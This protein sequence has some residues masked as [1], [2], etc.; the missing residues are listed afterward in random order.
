[1]KK[2]T[3]ILAVLALTISAFAKLETYDRKSISIFKTAVSSEAKKEATVAN[4]E[5]IHNQLFNR[6]V[7]MGR[8]D[9]NPIPAGVTDA[10]TL[11]AI[12]KEYTKMN[13]EQRAAKQWDIKDDFYGTNFITG[14]NVDKI[15]NGAYILFP[16]LNK[17]KVEPKK[18]KEGKIE[19]YS[20][21]MQIKVDIYAAD[22]KG[23][24]ENPVW[25]PRK[26]GTISAGS[27]DGLGNIFG[28]I[29]G[30]GAKTKDKAVQSATGATL[31]FLEKELRKQEMFKI[32]ALVTKAEPKKD[33]IA[34]GF[35]KNTGINVDDAYSIGYYVKGSDGNQK[36]VETGYVKVRKVNKEE[37]ETQLLIVNNP[38]NENEDDLFN[39]YDQ[40]VEY[41]LVGM[42]IIVSGG[43]SQFH[44]F[45]G[46][47][48]DGKLETVDFSGAASLTVEYDLGKT[49]QIPELYSFLSGEMV[50]GTAEFEIEGEKTDLEPKVIIAEAGLLYKHMMRRHSIYFGGAFNYAFIDLTIENSSKSDD[51]EDTKNLTALGGKAFLGYNYLIDKTIFFDVQVGYRFF[52][53]L[54]DTGDSFWETDEGMGMLDADEKFLGE[55]T[56]E[57]LKPSGLTAKVGI[58]FTL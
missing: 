18:D 37:S 38:K 33:K 12:V 50:F 56:D 55:D 54:K 8:F 9:Y 25:E 14:E 29:T 34:F 7:G 42:N 52:G 31:E 6:F 36:F 32:K 16:K 30:V 23:T 40:A 35:G 28:A 26:V 4:V 46:V 24:E 41:P 3:V 13:L 49:T 11:F 51:D 1:M 44:G 43:M 27:G 10:S 48:D 21:N 17:F 20:C 19:S 53:D 57:L 47:D 5:Y 45:D 58:G 2:L 22:N 15:I 39:E